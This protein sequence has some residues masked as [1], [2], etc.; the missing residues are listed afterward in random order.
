MRLTG[1]NSTNVDIEV[2]ERA[3]KVQVAVRT[4]DRDLA[5]SLQADL[6]GLVGRLE[7]KGF[8]TEAWAPA[9]SGHSPLAAPEQ[10]G[11]ANSRGDPRQPGSGT[12]Q[13]QPRGQGQNGS[14]HRQQARW[15]AQ[16]NNTIT[17]EETRTEPQ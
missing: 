15:M 9:V 5:K 16:V 6:G 11:F 13:Q 8:R 10:S 17:A 2:T 14:N 3:G 1:A 4:Q 12:G 7:N